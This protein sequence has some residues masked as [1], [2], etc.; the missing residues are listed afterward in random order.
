MRAYSMDLRER[1][2]AA[3][4]E[5]ESSLE[6]A[7]RMGVHDS[8]VRKL[9]RRRDRTG[10]IAPAP[11]GGGRGR[12]LDPMCEQALRAALDA[13]ND[14]TLEELRQELARRGK[15]VSITSVWRALARLGITL[16][17]NSARHRA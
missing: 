13:R 14:A 3:L 8:W 10:T 15:H 17:K 4:D 1:V 11:H 7:A 16:K 12:K 2:I 6:V 5:G 9:R